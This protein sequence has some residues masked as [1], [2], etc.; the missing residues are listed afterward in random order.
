MTDPRTVTIEATRRTLTQWRPSFME[1]LREAVR[2]QRDG[3]TGRARVL[4]G[5]VERRL[6]EAQERA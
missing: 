5:Q 3:R 4:A 1:L 2:A 6:R